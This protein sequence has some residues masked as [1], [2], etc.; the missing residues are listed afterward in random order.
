[1]SHPTKSAHIHSSW[2]FRL[3]STLL[4]QVIVPPN[5]CGNFSDTGP[6]TSALIDLGLRLH[7]VILVD[8]VSHHDLFSL[9]APKIR[10]GSVGRQ[11]K[12]G[13]GCERTEG[14]PLVEIAFDVSHTLPACSQRRDQAHHLRTRRQR[15]APF[16][17][18]ARLRRPGNMTTNADEVVVRRAHSSGQCAARGRGPRFG[19][20][21]RPLY[22]VNELGLFSKNGKV[23]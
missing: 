12:R 1:M 16:S 2:I 22:S 8:Q 6:P 5:S 21:V 3:K 7:Q 23:S 20:H 14:G 17:R 4:N 11:H 9:W 18:L 19:E 10:D 15:S 13:H